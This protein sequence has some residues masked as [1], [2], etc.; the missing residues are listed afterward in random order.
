MHAKPCKLWLAPIQATA[1]FD[2][3]IFINSLKLRFR[4][5]P[6]EFDPTNGNSCLPGLLIEDF[7]SKLQPYVPLIDT[8]FHKF[9][10]I[11]IK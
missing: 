3:D 11:V 9:E 2:R 5:Y 4:T 8:K 1:T 6:V 7:G 10:A